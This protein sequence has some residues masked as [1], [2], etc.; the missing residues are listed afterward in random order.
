MI[1]KETSYIPALTTNQLIGCV[2]VCVCEKETETDRGRQKDN[3]RLI[4]RERDKLT[5]TET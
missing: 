3:D 2:C 5:E 4:D 1:I